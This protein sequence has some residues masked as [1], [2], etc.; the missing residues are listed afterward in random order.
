MEGSVFKIGH[1]ARPGGVDPAGG[2]IQAAHTPDAGT[3]ILCPALPRLVAPI[4]IRNEVPGGGD[5]VRLPVGQDLLRHV[6]V[7]DGADGAYGHIQVFPD[8]GRQVPLFAVGHIV[9][10][11]LDAHGGLD[12]PGAAGALDN[13][14]LILDELQHLQGVLLGA[15]PIGKFGYAYPHLDHHIPAHPVPDGVQDHGGEADAV[16]RAAAKAVGPLVFIG[17]HELGD[18]PIVA[19]VEHDQVE[20]APAYHVGRIG[21]IAHHVLNVLLGHLPHH[22]PCVKGFCRGANGIFRPLANV[23][24]LHGCQGAIGVDIVGKQVHPGQ[25][26]GFEEVVARGHDAAAARLHAAFHHV[27][28]G[29][30]ALGGT[31]VIFDAQL[32]YVGVIGAVDLQHRQPASVRR[33]D[34]AVL[35]QFSAQFYRAK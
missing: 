9:D 32:R 22:G 34:D 5:E 29:G 28:H 35:K 15:A 14:H 27:Y 10:G 31:R 18:Q 33:S 21:I 8:I 20:T 16:G 12:V 19:A 17:G 4:V 24:Q 23:G 30:A 3:D 1:I 11:L 25:G 2:N 6:G 7:V 13:I 26:V